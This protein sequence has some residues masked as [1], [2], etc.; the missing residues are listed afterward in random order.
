M[1]R[2]RNT[3]NEIVVSTAAVPA[4]RKTTTT[5]PR[6]AAA[7]SKS[8][9]VAVSEEPVAISVQ[10]VV[11]AVAAPCAPKHEEIATLAYSYWVAR[12]CQGGSQDED[13]RRAEQELRSRN[14]VTA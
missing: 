9:P 4:R 11:T 8:Q 12:G 6:R 7:T 2:K 5:R 3:E 13:W 1:A 10:A 14:A